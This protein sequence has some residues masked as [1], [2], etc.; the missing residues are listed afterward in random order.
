[1]STAGR[2][3][4]RP[5]RRSSARRVLEGPEPSA[6]RG[7]PMKSRSLD[8]RNWLLAITGLL[9][10]MFVAGVTAAPTMAAPTV[11]YTVNTFP[12]TDGDL[13]CFG[14]GTPPESNPVQTPREV[15]QGPSATPL[16][17]SFPLRLFARQGMGFRAHVLPRH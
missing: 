14:G 4:E 1:M 8:A 6:R 12:S 7:P 11:R 2:E 9:V 16:P 5:Y 15:V 13:C 17:R 3:D 10:L